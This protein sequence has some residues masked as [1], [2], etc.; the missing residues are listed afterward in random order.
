MLDPKEPPFV[1]EASDDEVYVESAG[2]EL[3]RQL[4]ELGFREYPEE[5]GQLRVEVAEPQRKAE[6]FRRLRDL[7][8]CFS[9]GREWSP[10]EVFEYLREKGLLSGSFQSIAWRGPGNWVVREE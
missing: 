3:E 7:G 5:P 1:S 4:R 6:L 2:A 8:V 10:A 9:R